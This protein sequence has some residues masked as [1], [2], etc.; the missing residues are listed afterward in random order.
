V[1]RFFLVLPLPTTFALPLLTRGEAIRYYELPIWTLL[2]AGVA[3]ISQMDRAGRRAAWAVAGAY[4]LLLQGFTLS[5]YRRPEPYRGAVPMR[6]RL[7]RGD[8][9]SE[10]F[11]PLA[12]IVTRLQADRV[13]TVESP[14]PYF[15]G[16][17]LRFYR[18]CGRW[19]A[20][21]GGRVA[22]VSYDPSVPG[23]LRYSLR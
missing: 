18:L 9:T 11:L 5:F 13:E 6:F 1:Q 7:G 22:E 12:P 3:A 19:G 21:P 20:G 17:P 4:A 14:E 8:E 16:S 2:V 15:I 10:H 23:G